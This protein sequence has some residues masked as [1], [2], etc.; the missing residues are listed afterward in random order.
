MLRAKS[1][2]SWIPLVIRGEWNE[3]GLKFRLH[4]LGPKAKTHCIS[5]NKTSGVAPLDDHGART[6][7]YPTDQVV[8]DL[9]APPTQ[10]GICNGV[11]L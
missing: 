7:G 5:V 10:Q 4:A 11:C 9:P 2:A 1:A 8:I 6:Y 3:L